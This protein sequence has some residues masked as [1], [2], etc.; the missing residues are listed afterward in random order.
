MVH[1]KTCGGSGSISRYL[2]IITFWSICAILPDQSTAQT[3]PRQSVAPQAQKVQT[4]EGITEYTLANGLRILLAPDA[5]DQRVTVNMTYLVGA[6]HEGYGE[7][8]MA[9]LL[10]HLIFKGTPKTP[11]P[12]VEFAKRGFAFNGT[13]THDR[14]N[15]FAS[16]Q[17]EQASIDWYLAWQAD[18]MVNSFIARKDL[19]SEMTVVRNEYERAENNPVI[20]LGDRMRRAAYMWHN[21]GKSVLGAKSDIEN[22]DIVSLKN[23]YRRY[24][25]PDNAIV[26]VAGRFDSAATLASIVSAFGSL[27][28]PTDPLPR[29]YT[30]DT[31]QDG[32]RNV[33]LRRP[34]TAP[35]IA[36]SYHVPPMLHPDT[37]PLILLG[38]VMADETTGRLTKKLSSPT[39]YEPVLRREAGSQ[40]FGSQLGLSDNADNVQKIMT[41]ILE[42]VATVP[43]TQQE[44][45][46][47]KNKFNQS[48]KR[49]F[50]NANIQAGT[51]IEHAV[52]GDWRS[53]FVT[54]DRFTKVI[55]EDVNR[56]A[57]KYFIASNR[58]TG[59]I[60]PTQAPVR[61]PEPAQLDAVLYM[62]GFALNGQ[63]DASQDFDY[64]F[65][66]LQRSTIS[67]ELAQNIK[68]SVL[69]KPMRGDFVR[70]RM[71]LRFG[72]LDALSGRIAA[73]RL[74]GR[75]LQDGTPK[76]NKQQIQ[77]ELVKLNAAVNFNLGPTG[78]DV[79]LTVGK[80]QFAQAYDFIVHLLKESDLPVRAFYSTKNNFIRAV[81]GELNDRA[82]EANRE[83]RRYGNPYAKD[84]PRYPYTSQ[85]WLDE[86]KALTYEQVQEFHAKFYGAQVAQV[87]VVGAVD[88]SSV[89]AQTA[90]LLE[91]WTAPVLWQRLPYPFS[92]VVPTRQMF[93][94]PDKAS[95]KIWAFTRVPLVELDPENWQLRLATRIFGVGPASRL[96]TRL[97]EKDG[98]SYDLAASVQLSSYEKSTGWSLFCDVAPANLST[99]EKAVKEELARSLADGFSP[100]EVEQFKKQFLQ[101]RKAAR[102]GDDHAIGVLMAI[103]EFNQDWDLAL[104][105]DKLIESFTTEQIN[106]VW[107]KYLKPDQLVWGIF[108][109]VAKTK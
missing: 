77:D 15:Y 28:R 25:R 98:L 69:S 26:M 39:V 80:D 20:A 75:L 70:L 58:T 3:S 23:F 71:K 8:G 97:R 34:A 72:S 54:R 18:A 52:A 100:Q 84:D 37:E 33:V 12:K 29:T 11:Q 109:D 40:F 51:V 99:A 17:S 46:Q 66:N 45:E 9:H 63:G 73:G 104:K 65:A 103:Q 57:Q 6:R 13:T 78:G 62:Q 47:A 101:E 93:D 19:D 21:Y 107:R 86:L 85:E 56:V 108:S 16:F 95:S 44:F 49:V 87:V 1:A 68:L 42:G 32:E 106:A 41:D 83:F 53:A 4:V 91:N 2:T 14:T 27:A 50:S 30:M 22:V 81:E 31:A 35:F 59:R 88:P 38:L 105:N 79:D 36:S 7:S 24:Y 61:A 82:T 43:I 96:W 64:S 76:Y 92:D 5:S 74:V 94:T 48:L 90:R 55:L 67:T 60:V 89:Q 10:E 102:S